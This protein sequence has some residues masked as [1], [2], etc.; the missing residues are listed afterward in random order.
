MEPKKPEQILSKIRAAIE[1]LESP[2]LRSR[3]LQGL[4]TPIC[5]RRTCPTDRGEAQGDLWIFL[6]VPGHEDLALAYS[7]EGY[8]SIGICWGLVLV[9]DDQ[10]GSSGNWYL[11]LYGL[12]VES[13]YFEVN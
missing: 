6:I 2:R 11:S 5:E 12:L 8:G 3:I 4:I 10:Y 1:E 7:E 9:H 13:G